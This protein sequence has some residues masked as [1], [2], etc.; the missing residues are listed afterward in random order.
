[1]YSGQSLLANVNSSRAEPRAVWTVGAVPRGPWTGAARWAGGPVALCA[2]CPWLSVPE[3]APVGKP[4]GVSPA[5]LPLAVISS[6]G[7]GSRG[8]GP[9]PL[10]AVSLS[11][12][13]F[14]ALAESLVSFRD[15]GREG[16]NTVLSQ[17]GEEKKGLQSCGRM[18]WKGLGLK[19]VEKWCHPQF[20]EDGR[21]ESEALW[22]WFVAGL[23]LAPGGLIRDRVQARHDPPPR[24]G[25][26]KGASSSGGLCPLLLSQRWAV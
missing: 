2:R 7:S 13:S 25:E 22:I 6:D 16:E 26:P 17:T 3:C 1:M 24:L 12:Y 9:L 19:R 20:T 21:A 18:R 4:A 11:P 14:S 15:R 8:D 23:G 10:P 5:R